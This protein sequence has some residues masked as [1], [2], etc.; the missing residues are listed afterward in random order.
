MILP[1][2]HLPVVFVSLAQCALLTHSFTLAQEVL[3]IT[4]PSLQIFA[5]SDCLI[6]SFLPSVIDNFK[7]FSS[8]S[9][10][11]FLDTFFDISTNSSFLPF[12]K[13]LMSSTKTFNVRRGFK[14]C[15]FTQCVLQHTSQKQATPF[16]PKE[17]FFFIHSFML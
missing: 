1:L 5:G 16:R 6:I 7:G 14:N 9:S 17:S 4:L 15:H 2:F 12:M 10:F 8:V 13:A 3:S 11:N